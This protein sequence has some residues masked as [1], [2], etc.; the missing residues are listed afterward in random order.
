MEMYDEQMVHG[1]VTIPPNA[2]RVVSEIP[3]VDSRSQADANLIDE[4]RLGSSFP[5][6]IAVVANNSE[7]NQLPVAASQFIGT[8]SVPSSS[9]ARN[10]YITTAYAAPN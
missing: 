8:S 2:V 3:V 4:W 6:A 10:S 1:A 5:V 7:L 9:Q